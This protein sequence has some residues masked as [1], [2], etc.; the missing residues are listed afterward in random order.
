MSVG[1]ALIGPGRLADW[2]IAPSMKS[3]RNTR[4]VGVLSRDKERGAAFATK[5][6]FERSYGSMVELLSDPEVDAVY[7]A[8]PIGLHGPQAIQAAKGG[9]HVFVQKPLA[10]N[11]EESQA[12]LSACQENKVRLGVA[13]KGRGHPAHIKARE[14]IA[15]GEL[16]AIFLVTGRLQ[17]T[18]HKGWHKGWWYDTSLG[19][20][21]VP[22]N[23]V[24]W[25]DL[26]R[27]ILGCEF[28]EVSA[29]VAPPTPDN[30]FDDLAVGMFRFDN[31]VYGSMHVS[32]IVPRPLGSDRIE[33][34]GSK[35]T[36][37]TTYG[38]SRAYLR[39]DQHSYIADLQVATPAGSTTYQFTLTNLFSTEIEAF[40]RAIEENTEPLANG[41]DGLRTDQVSAAMYESARLG[42]NV[43]IN[44]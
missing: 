21:I 27:F 12:V 22:R 9:K 41:I 44:L 15:S 29:F 8:T 17:V 23:G 43:K 35:G 40:N 14:I 7:L 42:K 30:P 24:H 16:G 5:H 1:W 2:H 33:Y 11:P 37:T 32:G 18:P 31:G 25:I 26:M 38:A 39:E 4:M 10:R 34:F 36:M 3:A 6:G 28:E 19:S 13:Y 20:G